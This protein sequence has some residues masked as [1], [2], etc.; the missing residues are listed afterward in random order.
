MNSIS[1]YFPLQVQTPHY[2]IEK[3]L[4][5]KDDIFSFQEDQLTV[6]LPSKCRLQWAALLRTREA[7]PTLTGQAPEPPRMVELI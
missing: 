7:V 2:R 1:G 3:V 6:R 4:L 5:S